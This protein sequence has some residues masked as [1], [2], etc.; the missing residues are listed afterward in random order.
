MM[1]NIYEALEHA[2][3]TVHVIQ[4]T[5]QNIDGAENHRAAVFDD[6]APDVE[7]EMIALYHTI[8]SALPSVEH[9]SVLFI[10]SASN[11]GTTTIARQLAKTISL[12]MEKNI[13]LIDIDRSRPDLHVYE[14]I[15]AEK[16]VQEVVDTG[17]LIDKAL[18]RVEETSLY[19]MP[20]FQ[21][22]MLTPKALELAKR[23][24]FWEPLKEKFDLVIVDSP[25]ATVFPDGP[26]FASCVDGVILVVEAEKTRWP[27]ALSV[28]DKII[29]SGGRILGIVFNKRK[30]YIPKW[31]YKRV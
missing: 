30:F 7:E 1:S 14:G 25:P 31:L 11:E 6:R 8:V 10:G 5:A 27:V 12:R 18:Y 17:D 19:V 4:P 20:L 2:K 13:L 3:T 29:K 16:S 9:R 24:V 26:G 21:T 28:K 23:D 15:R 22:T